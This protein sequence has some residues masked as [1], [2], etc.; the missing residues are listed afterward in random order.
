MRYLKA[1]LVGLLTAVAAVVAWVVL[2]NVW[3]V[4][5]GMVR[6]E[7]DFMVLFHRRE[8]LLVAACGFAAGSILMLRLTRRSTSK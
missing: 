5:R 6:D 4:I 7:P 8:I 2:V 3:M 1:G